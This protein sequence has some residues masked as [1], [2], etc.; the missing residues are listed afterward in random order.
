[1][2]FALSPL[3]SLPKQS[4]Q[5]KD[6][7]HAVVEVVPGVAFSEFFGEQRL[8]AQADIVEP[9]NAAKPIPMIHFSISAN[10]VLPPHE[11]PHQI[12]PIH[13]S[14]LIYGKKFNVVPIGRLQSLYGFHLVAFFHMGGD[15]FFCNSSH[16]AF[17]VG[18]RSRIVDAWQEHVHFRSVLVFFQWRNL[19]IFVFFVGRSLYDF[20]ISPFFDFING[21]S[22]LVALHQIVV[23]GVNGAV[24]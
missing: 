11:V 15:F 8:V 19:D 16:P 20:L 2:P 6:E 14:H 12:A 17:V 9:W 23:D 5:A 4:E 18:S 24:K 10:V 1:M 22:I 7:R 13:V 21:M 3:S